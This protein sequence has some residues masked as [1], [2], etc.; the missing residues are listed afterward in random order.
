[1]SPDSVNLPECQKG[2][3]TEREKGERGERA[4]SRRGQTGAQRAEQRAA[5]RGRFYRRNQGQRA[6]G[7]ATRL[8]LLP[9]HYTMPLRQVYGRRCT[10]VL[11]PLPVPVPLYPPF[12]PLFLPR[13]I[14]L[15]RHFISSGRYL[16]HWSTTTAVRLH[17]AVTRIQMVGL[18]SVRVIEEQ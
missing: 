7:K 10:D 11:S 18:N 13:V 2:A 3:T 9:L 15:P 4:R 5:V 17:E 12:R 8:A 16:P 14:H 1:M 6:K